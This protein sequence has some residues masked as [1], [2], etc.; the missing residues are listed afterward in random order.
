MGL[1]QYLYR[2]IDPVQ[3]EVDFGNGKTFTYETRGQEVAY[4]RKVNFLHKWVED[5]LNEGRETNCEYIPFHLE[6]MAGLTQ[7]CA[8]VIADPSLGPELLP[9]MGRFFF[10]NTKYD[11]YYIEDVGDVLTAL[12]RILAYE[13]ERDEPGC[14]QY[15]YY[16]SW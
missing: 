6:A 16:S 4:F 13:R 2:G 1:D 11:E 10:G 5:H 15:S 7:T 8:T 14:G 3:Q 12:A 9:T